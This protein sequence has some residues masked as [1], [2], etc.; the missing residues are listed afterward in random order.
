MLLQIL[1]FYA[2]RIVFIWI[3]IKVDRNETFCIFCQKFMYSLRSLC[4]SNLFHRLIKIIFFSKLYNRR[5]V[6]NE[7]KW[8]C[9]QK[10]VDKRKIMSL[11]ERLHPWDRNICSDDKGSRF[12]SN[13]IFYLQLPSLSAS[14]NNNAPINVWWAWLIKIENDF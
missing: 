6:N 5:S 14:G 4:K 13:E 11:F 7:K 2:I 10:V 3:L 9:G 12:R 1:I 8:Y